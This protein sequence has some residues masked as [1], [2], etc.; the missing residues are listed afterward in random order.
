MSAFELW[1]VVAV[2]CVVGLILFL[3]CRRPG[4]RD[5][6]ALR[7]VLSSYVIIVI[8]GAMFGSGTLNADILLSLLFLILWLWG[9]VRALVCR[10]SRYRKL[11][12]IC[13][14]ILLLLGA[15]GAGA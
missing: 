2:L 7:L 4:W 14:G 8:Q 9:G 11:T 12:F 10:S 3:G 15:V 6:I 13:W 5:L 1:Y